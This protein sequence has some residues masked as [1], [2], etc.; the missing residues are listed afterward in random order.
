MRVQSAARWKSFPIRTAHVVQI[1]KW[2]NFWFLV[3]KVELTKMHTY[4]LSE[5]RGGPGYLQILNIYMY[6]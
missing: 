4:A 6:M 2:S 5:A 1:M 3:A